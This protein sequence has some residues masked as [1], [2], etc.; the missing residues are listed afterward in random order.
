MVN[1]INNS[2]REYFKQYQLKNKTIKQ[3]YLKQYYLKNKDILKNNSRKYYSNNRIYCCRRNMLYKKNNKEKYRI[4]ERNRLKNNIN[5][6]LARLLRDRFN[7]LM[8]NNWKKASIL[9]LIGCTLSQLKEHLEKQ[10]KSGMSWNNRGFYGWYIDHIIPLCN[11]NL[12]NIEEQQKA[13][14]YTNLQPLWAKE[15]WSKFKKLNHN[16]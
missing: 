7:G 10:F 11:F 3:E 9:E 8:H 12:I 16:I 6:K 5:Y 15:N 14:H 13:F 1:N 2:R 4:Q